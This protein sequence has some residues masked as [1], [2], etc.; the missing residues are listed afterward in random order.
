M[1]LDLTLFFVFNVEW[2]TLLQYEP[3]WTDGWANSC[4]LQLHY[5]WALE[6]ENVENRFSR[7]AIC[8]QP[9]PQRRCGGHRLTQLLFVSGHAQHITWCHWLIRGALFELLI[10]YIKHFKRDVCD[11]VSS[12]T[13]GATLSK[14][15]ACDSTCGRMDHWQ[16]WQDN[17]W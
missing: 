8:R 12:E 6:W 15:W 1:S 5:Q 3:W 13:Q 9:L 2:R 10:K 11:S 14:L 4:S 16:A 7:S 17:H